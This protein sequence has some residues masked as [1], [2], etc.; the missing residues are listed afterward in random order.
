MPYRK[1]LLKIYDPVG[2][3]EASPRQQVQGNFAVALGGL[4]GNNA[5][6]AGVI[7]ALYR[8]GKKPRLISCT[9]GQIRF[10]YAYLRGLTPGSE[11]N[12]YSMLQ[13]HFNSA[14]PFKDMTDVNLNY[15][16]MTWPFQHIRPSVPEFSADMLGNLTRSMKQFLANPRDFSVWREMYRMM[17]ART[18]VSQ[19]TLFD[20]DVFSDIAGLFNA[21][22]GSD[23]HGVGVMFNAY[24]FVKGEEYVFMNE[25]AAALTGHTPGA[26][27]DSRPWIKYRKITEEAVRNALRLYEYGFHEEG[28][29]LDG[30]YF[31]GLILSEIPNKGNG[32]DTIVVGRPLANRWL[33]DAPSSLIEL[34]DMQTEVN[35]LGGYL[36][37][38][39]Q[40]ELINHLLETGRPTEPPANATYITIL[41]V[42]M[43][44]Q[45][46]WWEYVL[47]DEAVFNSAF[48]R[49]RAEVCP[50]LELPRAA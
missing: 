8:C 20:P 33:G 47:E 6:G 18:L 38:K 42:E 9:S 29:L 17:P 40:I 11:V 22:T 14:Q 28:D 2:P 4:A 35:F 49:T 16:L 7:E 39:G 36:G 24:D 10:T 46:G 44:R 48:H 50:R 1:K 30:A 3:R 31:R 13:R 45:R 41:E 19:D 5:H 37:E 27:S 32:I 21:D 34:R 15:K 26:A 25:T 43:D 12:P 23:G